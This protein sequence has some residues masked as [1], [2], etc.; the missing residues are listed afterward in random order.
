[1]A[2]KLDDYF[3]MYGYRIDSLR[4]PDFK[5]RKF[6]NYIRCAQFNAEGTNIPGEY[7]D[8]IKIPISTLSVQH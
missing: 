7:F 6:W 1:M 5:T 3:D 2:K 4:V 8:I